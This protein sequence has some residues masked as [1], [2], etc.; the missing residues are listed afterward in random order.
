MRKVYLFDLDGTLI[1]SMPVGVGIVLGFLD[2]QGIPYGPDI[3]K[4]LTPLGYKGVAKYYAENLG[5][6]YSPEEIYANFQEKTKKA[7]GESIPLKPHVK[8]VLTALAAQG[9]RLNVLTASPK[10]LTE[11]CLKRLGVFDLFE[12][13]W[14]IDDFGLSKA[15]GEIYRKTAARLGVKTIDCVMVDDNVNVLKVA[16]AEGLTVI[17]IFDETTKDSETEMRE[18]ADFYCADFSE[19]PK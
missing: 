4:T 10:F 6:K 18:L 9:A 3:V 17:G 19:F 13:V 5:A 2:E 14:S 8:E 1:D 12:N 11:L 7:Y 16:Q 15:D